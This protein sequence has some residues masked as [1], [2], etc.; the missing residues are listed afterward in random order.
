MCPLSLFSSIMPAMSNPK[1]GVLIINLG[2]PDS[3]STG[4]VR[5]YLREFLMDGRVMDIP[6]WRRFLLVNFVIAPFRAPESS[7]AYRQL[8]TNEGSPLK[9][10]GQQ[11]QGLLQQALG[12]DFLVKLAMRYQ[13]PSIQSVLPHFENKGFKQL[14]II[15][16]YP[17]Y[18]SSSTGSTIEDVMNVVKHWEVVPEIKCISRFFD[19][20]LFIKA[21]A[22]TGKK[23]MAQGNFD[24]YLFS[25]HGLPE[26][27]ILKASCGDYCKLGDCCATYHGKNQ[28]CYRAQCFETTRLLVQELGIKKDEYT[29]CFQ[30]RLGKTPWIK[31]YTDEVIKQLAGRGIKKVLTF[32]PAFVADC[33]ETSVEIGV[34][35]KKL[36][37]EHGGE[38]WQ[39]VESLNAHPLWVECLKQMVT[40]SP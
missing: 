1:T 9:V 6:F 19:H 18:A 10:Y 33:L 27:Q 39:L 12:G 22:Q 28:Y 31:P 7:K 4:D 17:Q 2:T 24:H 29:I 11:L 26:R 25:Y 3:S 37:L 38:H 30:S 5:K 14:I 23:Y 20:P 13:S 40:P 16:L 36:F 32:S 8:W 34:E 35:Y 21:F 15:P